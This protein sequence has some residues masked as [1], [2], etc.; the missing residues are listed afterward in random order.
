MLTGSFGVVLGM[1]QDET[2]L[3]P[4][5]MALEPLRPGHYWIVG[6]WIPFFVLNIGGE[7]FVWRSFVLPRQQAHFGR[8]A[9]LVNGI[10]WWLFHAAFPWQVLF[11]LVPIALILPFIVQRRR[12]TWIGIVIHGAFGAAG[13]LVLA[14][15]LV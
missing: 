11:T 12:S 5:F 4:S 7:E 8:R 1:L 15:G 2:K 13:F 10:L 3:H 9:W 6:A 14:F